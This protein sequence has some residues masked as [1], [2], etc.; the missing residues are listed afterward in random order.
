MNKGAGVVD[1]YTRLT[2]MHAEIGGSLP[3]YYVITKI[4]PASKNILIAN[5]L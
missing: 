2:N 5:N 4:P 1:I 3:G